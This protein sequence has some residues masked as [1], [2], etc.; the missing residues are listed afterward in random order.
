MCVAY[1]FFVKRGLMKGGCLRGAPHLGGQP[2]LRALS[3][4]RTLQS[5]TKPAQKEREFMSVRHNR[6][7]TTMS[8]LSALLIDYGIENTKIPLN[9]LSYFLLIYIIIFFCRF[10]LGNGTKCRVLNGKFSKW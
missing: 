2:H 5:R 7:Y 8:L 4:H 1:L 9:N 6:T 3:H 10:R